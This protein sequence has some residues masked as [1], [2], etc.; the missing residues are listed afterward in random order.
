M[1]KPLFGTDGIRGIPNKDLLPQYILRIG[2][3]YGIILKKENPNATVAIAKDTRVSGDMLESL[4][5]AGL[6]SVGINTL[7]VGVLPTPALAYITSISEVSGGIMISA[8]HNPKEHNG[9]K[10]FSENGTKLTKEKQSEIEKIL[11]ADSPIDLTEAIGTCSQ[12]LSMRELYFDFILKSIPTSFKGMK[13]GIDC[14][15]GATSILAKEIFEK[16]GA[17]VYSIH[18]DIANNNINENCGSTHTDSLVALVKN[19]KLDVG[20]AFDGDGDRVMTVDAHGNVVDGDGMLYI[21]SQ[22]LKDINA[23]EKDTVVTTVMSNKGFLNALKDKGINVDITAVGDANV[24][25]SMNENDFS[26]GGE[27]SGHIIVKKYAKTGDGILSALLLVSAMKRNQMEINTM[28]NELFIFPSI[29]KNIPVNNKDKIMENDA[30]LET[31]S[32]CEQALGEDGRILVRASGTE[33]LVR[34]LVEAK[35]IELCEKHIKTI[36]E[37]ILLINEG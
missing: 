35:T 33:H 19:K 4:L 27:T 24:W 23:L 32:K 5:S 2:Q 3:A 37:Q 9:I 1:N 25:H 10:L 11:I 22:Y 8:S 29:L 31:I 12:A 30:L 16:T 20:F 15:N 13:I 36:K 28:L 14:A 7:L 6:N 34:V 18:D 26:L 17:T 21:L